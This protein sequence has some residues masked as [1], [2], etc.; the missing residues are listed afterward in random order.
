M[1]FY[2]RKILR[3][4]LGERSR[5]SDWAYTL[6]DPELDSRHDEVYLFFETSTPA[7]G[8]FLPPIQRVQRVLSPRR[9]VKPTGLSVYYLPP[10]SPSAEMKNEYSYNPTSRVCRHGVGRGNF[11]VL[12]L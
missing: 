1:C 3:K 6:K 5:F 11:T 12:I 7:V 4:E 8:P 9:R 2:R 10:A